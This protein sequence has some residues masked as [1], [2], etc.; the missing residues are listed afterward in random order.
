MRLTPVF[1]LWL[2]LAMPLCAELRKVEMKVGGLDCESCASSVDRVVK[3]IRGVDTVMFDPKANV[4]AVTFKPDNKVT[5]ASIRDALKGVG[6]TPAEAHM[7][8][9]GDVKHD[10]GEWQFILSGPETIFKATVA[11]EAKPGTAVVEGTVSPD[12]VLKIE[13]ISA[14]P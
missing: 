1:G 3:R 7:T 12:D 6:Y 8:A 14:L 4:V 2:L 9:S 13:K 5:L 11:S 10:N